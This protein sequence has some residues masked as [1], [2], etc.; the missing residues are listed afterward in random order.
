VDRALTAAAAWVRG[1]LPLDGGRNEVGYDPRGVR[2]I[3]LY[4]LRSCGVPADD[5]TVVR[6]LEAVR[7]D[8][9]DQGGT[10]GGSTNYS[11]ALALLALEAHLSGRGD[12][13][14]DDRPPADRARRLAPADQALVRLL[15]AKIKGSQGPLGGFGYAPGTGTGWG[16]LSNTQFAL[17]GLKAASRL[18]VRAPDGVWRTALAYALAL[19]EDTGPEVDRVAE[20]GVK[21]KG[22]GTT[23]RA[24]AK[25]RARGFKYQP[26]GGASG[27]MTAAGVAS[28]VICRSELLGTDSYTRET[29]ARAEKGIRDGLAWL[30]L[31]FAVRGNPGPPGPPGPSNH[32]YYLYGLERAGVLAA[33]AFV[34]RHDWYGEGARYLLDAQDEDGSWDPWSDFR[35]VPPR[36]R[37]PAGVAPRGSFLDT[38]YAILFLKRATFRVARG[39]VTEEVS[40]SLDLSGAGKLDDDAFRDLFCAVFRR[41]LAASEDGRAGTSIDFVRMGPRAIPLLVLAL[42]DAEEPRRAAASD[43]LLRTTGETQGYHPA[44]APESRAAAVARWESWWME[45][46]GALAADAKAGRFGDVRK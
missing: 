25:D 5:P 7:R 11:A 46:K 34:G 18:G 8:W 28:V 16:D 35:P 45:R 39:T 42:E 19:Q 27:S 22:Y 41:H 26:R 33:V 15:A 23:T 32:Y 21:E 4:A 20:V 37:R 2:A 24:V 31:N 44:A 17:L 29:D 38:C 30:G 13:A 9:D 43:A 10:G 12:A 40:D 1:K 6:L 3:G 36:G 14:E